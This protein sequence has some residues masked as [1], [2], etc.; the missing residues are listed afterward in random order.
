LPAP[1][2]EVSLTGALATG[3]GKTD[4]DPKRTSKDLMVV[5][6]DV[7]DFKYAH[8]KMIGTRLDY[9]EEGEVKDACEGDS[10]DNGN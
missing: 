3:W 1:D 7:D 2:E 9:N 8:P 5:D 6:L 10:G 4:K